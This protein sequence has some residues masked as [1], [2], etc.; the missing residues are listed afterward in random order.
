MFPVL[1]KQVIEV[2]FP[3]VAAKIEADPVLEGALLGQGLGRWGPFLEMEESHLQTLVGSVSLLLLAFG[4]LLAFAVA[5]AAGWEAAGLAGS[6][7]VGAGTN[8]PPLAST[9][10][11]LANAGTS[12]GT[13]LSSMC[14]CILA[15]NFDANFT[16]TDTD[17]VSN[18]S[19]PVSILLVLI[20]FCEN[21]ARCIKN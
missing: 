11:L 8:P 9:K 1:A 13:E 5:L 10:K 6:A 14:S 16:A 21:E 15:K 18:L 19:S 20:E 7:A 4:L 2:A 12:L 17:L 3:L